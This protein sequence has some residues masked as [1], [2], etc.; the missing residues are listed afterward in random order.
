MLWLSWPLWLYVQV[1]V[2]CFQRLKGSKEKKKCHLNLMCLQT[3]VLHVLSCLGIISDNSNFGDFSKCLI[4]N[5]GKF[6]WW[7]E[8]VYSSSVVWYYSA[9]LLYSGFGTQW[10]K[11]GVSQQRGDMYW[12]ENSQSRPP[13]CV[14]VT[15]KVWVCIDIPHQQ[16]GTIHK[17]WW[18]VPVSSQPWY[19]VWWVYIIWSSLRVRVT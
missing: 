2:F 3:K 5:C 8:V 12:N 18:F 13:Y 19:F 10:E 14:S 15:P 1:T 17:A 6:R 9:G 16:G 4:Q 7:E 11:L